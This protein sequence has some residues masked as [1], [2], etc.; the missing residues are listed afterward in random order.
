MTSS[1]VVEIKISALKISLT[2]NKNFLDYLQL[3]LDNK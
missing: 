3:P 1:Q 2:M